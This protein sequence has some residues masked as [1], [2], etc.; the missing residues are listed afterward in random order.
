MSNFAEINSE[1][2]VQS[3]SQFFC[4]LISVSEADWFEAHDVFETIDEHKGQQP[5]QR[6]IR[7]H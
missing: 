5:L 1:L 4:H 2:L 6:R 3:R 7:S